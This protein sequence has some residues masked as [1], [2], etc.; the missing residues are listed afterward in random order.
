MTNGSTRA[1][2]IQTILALAILPFGASLAVAADN[3][4]SG[5]CHAHDDVVHSSTAHPD[6]AC[7]E[8]HTNVPAEHEGEDLEPLTDDM[9]CNE[10][11]G[12]VQ[13]AIKRSAHGGEAACGDC[14]GAPH[15]INL[16]EELASAVSPVNQIKNCGACHDDPPGLVDGYMT[17]E[18]GSALLRSGLIDAPSCSDCHGDHQILEADKARAATSHSKSPEMCGECHVLVLNEWQDHSAHG[19]AWQAEEEGPVCVDCHSSHGIS[20]PTTDESR[21]V[22]AAN[23]GGCHEEYLTSFRDSFH[24]KASYLGMSGGAT[25]SDCHTPHRNLSADNPE[26]SVHADNVLETC[27]NCHEGVTASFATFDPHNDPTNPDDIFPVYVVWVFMTGLLI[28]VFV[29]FG[30]HDLLWLQRSLVGVMRGEFDEERYGGSGK[31]VRRFRRKNMR[32]HVVIISTF[33]LLALTGLPL[34]FSDAAWSQQLVD[35]LGGIDSTRFL[36]RIAAI[37]TFGYMFVHI[38]DVFVRW[39]IRGEKGMF[40]GPNSMMPQPKDVS[41]FIGNIKYF[42][43][44]GERPPGDRWTYF[45]KF[46]YLAVFW[47]VMIIGLS[48]LVLWFPGFFTSFLPGWTLNAAHVIHSDEAL[49]ATGFIFVFHFFHTHLRPES[50]PMDL[51]IFTGRMSLERFK[52]ERP[53]EY[54]RLVDNNELEDYLVEGPNK[55]QRRD[56]YVFGSIFLTIGILL[57]IGIIWALLTH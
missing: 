46:D 6:L 29:F 49:L 47:G 37:G 32:M 42:F 5:D 9:S 24:G 40:W 10:C 45:E 57:A 17:S 33:M 55:R 18:H 7:S 12:K 11:H 25:C 4:C 31:Y 43:Y 3:T 50:F 20:D 22:S 38:A 36:H 51:V 15:E 56:A 35:I 27:G 48:G 52:A 30:I 1:R 14:H 26:S 54:Q 28:G 8:C 13:R 2:L 39:A 19:L 16:I 41:D 44:L 34:K 23:C 21:H 53:L